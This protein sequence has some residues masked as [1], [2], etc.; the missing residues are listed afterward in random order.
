MNKQALATNFVYCR[1]RL[2]PLFVQDVS[3]DYL[4][5]FASKQL[6]FCGTHT[7][8]STTYQGHFIL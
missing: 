4:G 1:F 7:S 6:G 8:G 2:T 5:T 3:D